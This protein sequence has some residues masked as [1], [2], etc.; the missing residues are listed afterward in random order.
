MAY[1]ITGITDSVTTCD[2]CGKN[3]LKRAVALVNDA[4]EEFFFGTNCAGA[5]VHGRKSKANENNVT[6]EAQVAQK[7]KDVL[8]AVLDMVARG[9]NY[10]E[11]T[12]ELSS[13]D[14]NYSATFGVYADTGNKTP[15]RIYWKSSRAGVEL[16]PDKY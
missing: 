8:P 7:C 13:T 4:G 5:A 10:R 2:C 11:V 6:L 1:Q 12:R 16:A 3:N 15:L 14:H 9:L